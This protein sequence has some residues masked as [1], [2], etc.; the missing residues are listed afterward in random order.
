VRA[1]RTA[2]RAEAAGGGGERSCGGRAAG[3]GRVHDAASAPFLRARWETPPDPLC[4]SAQGPPGGWGPRLKGGATL[5][6][7]P[8]GFG[9]EGP[10]PPP[11]PGGCD[12]LEDGSRPQLRP[13][14]VRT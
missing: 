5:R 9:L 10:R 3:N 1:P 6:E 13:L 12:P 14:S 7:R 8:L 11:A 2:A 4:G